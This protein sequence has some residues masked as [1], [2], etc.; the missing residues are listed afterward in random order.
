[1]PSLDVI[2]ALA[3]EELVQLTEEGAE[4]E[5]LKRALDLTCDQCGD[6]QEEALRLFWQ[7]AAVLRETAKG[8]HV[9]PSTLDEIRAL[10]SNGTRRLDISFD[11]KLNDRI[12][13]AWLGRC[14]GCMLG[15]P[16]EGWRRDKIKALLKAGDAYPLND[17]FPYVEDLPEGTLWHPSYNECLKGNITHSVRDD[18]TDYTILGLHILEIRG[19]EFEP[20]D[21]ANSWLMLLPYHKTYTAERVA[22]RNFVNGIY[23]PESALVMN[24]YREWIGAQIRCD[25]FGYAAAGWPEKAAE[26]AFRDACISHTKNGIYGEMFFAALIAA[27]LATDDLRRAIQIGLAEIPNDSRFAE[28]VR[29]MLIW[30]DQGTWEQTWDLIDQKYGHY[31]PVHTINNAAITLMGL[32][33]AGGD[34]TQ[35][36]SIA[37]MGGLDTDCNGATAG[38]VMGAL[39]GAKAL[40]AHWVDPLNDTL[41]SALEGM[42]V[43]KISDLAART[44]AV[45]KQV[46]GGS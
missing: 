16:V 20:L 46:H 27:C 34:F 6:V 40:P 38:S 9:E 14:A 15:K 11:E 39:L 45:A 43:N 3:Y 25:A 29:D 41:H 28:M 42:N 37:V 32:L 5:E 4:T 19:P 21:V 31:H 36:I 12:P 13:G 24:P 8:P 33:H 44:V 1:M 18:D 2:K 7:Q 17:Y 30:C 22:Y 10:R 26:L 23:P 35:A